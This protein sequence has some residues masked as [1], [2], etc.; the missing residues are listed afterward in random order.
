L[1]DGGN[2]RRETYRLAIPG[3]HQVESIVRDVPHALRIAVKMPDSLAY[4][5]SVEL[6]SAKR[7]PGDEE[8]YLR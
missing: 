4:L 7:P 6:A 5:A 8:G 1:R 2:L 3:K